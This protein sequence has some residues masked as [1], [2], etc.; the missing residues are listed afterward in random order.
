MARPPARFDFT[1]PVPPL[2]NLG[3]VHLIAIGGAGMSAVARLLLARGVTVSGSDA[4]DGATLHALRD[5]G[6]RVHVGHDPAHL[7]AVDTVVV[8]SAI[9][10]DNVELAA[11]RAAGLRVLHRAQA[12]AALMEG[13]R[14][15]AVAG[16][17]GKTT[18]TSMLVV[19]LVAAGADP[20]FASGGEIAQLGT[21]ATLGAGPAFVVEADESDGSFLV[22]RP[23]VAV[24]TNVQPDHLDFYGTAEQVADAYA[25]FAATVPEGGLVVVCHDDPGSRRLGD[26]LRRRGGRTVVSYGYGEGSDLRVLGTTA[27][28]LGTRSVLRD[29][30]ADRTLDLLVPGEHNVLDACGAYLAAVRGLG[31]DPDAVLSGLSGFGGARRRFEV[32]GEVEGVTVVDDYAHNPAKVAAVVG[33]AAQVVRRAGPGSLRV[34][35]QPHLYSRTRDFAADFARA[36]APADQVVILDVYG[37]REAPLDGVTSALVGDPLADLPGERTVVV[38]ATRDEAVAAVVGAARPG[39]LVLTVGA[40]DVTALAPLV[41]EGLRRRAGGGPP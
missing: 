27:D 28:G 2:A 34:V 3:R 4:A 15:V 26:D 7:E 5:S 36:L 14:R 17:N 16:A 37:A 29:E 25:G 24:V 31:A 11:A 22:Y 1:A 38:G 21:N 9:R 10:D 40:G 33:T 35:F 20:S 6:A 41:L 8:S 32:R 12:L 19:G 39:D 13:S 30:G 18:T 23:E